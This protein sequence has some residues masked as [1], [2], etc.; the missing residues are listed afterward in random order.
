MQR[1]VLVAAIAIVGAAVAGATAIG[2]HEPRYRPLPD[3][4]RWTTVLKA[5]VGLEGLTADRHGNLYT[6]G[7]GA[8]PCPILRTRPSGGPAAV[9]GNIPAPCNPAGLAFDADGDLFIA[10]G[11][12]IVTLPPSAA[13]P[14]T[15]TVFATDVP[16]A[17]GVAFD[18]RG[19][20]WV[21]DGGIGQG[22][23]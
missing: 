14:P 11:S 8:D 9:V 22:R 17:N 23:V 10:D 16:G 13:Q 3:N 15:A 2:D 20:L 5:S 18:R 4:A 6:P 21:S 7:R 12:R 19:K 1:L